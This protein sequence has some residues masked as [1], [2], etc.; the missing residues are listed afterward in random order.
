MSRS[1]RFVAAAVL[2]AGA[3]G[4][5]GGYLTATIPA[6]PVYGHYRVTEDMALFRCEYH[7]N[8][9]CGDGPAFPTGP[10][11]IVLPG[12]PLGNCLAGMG[13]AG[14]SMGLCDPVDGNR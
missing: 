13:A 2:A 3:L 11:S 8:R 6:G 9:E 7:G 12:D 10:V 14:L 5:A 4:W 1:G